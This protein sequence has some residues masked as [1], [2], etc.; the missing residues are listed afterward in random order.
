MATPQQVS[1]RVA[2][3]LEELTA[4]IAA[5]EQQVALLIALVERQQS[6]SLDAKKAKAND[7]DR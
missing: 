7:A 2:K 6:A 4:R 1:I 5:L 3:Q